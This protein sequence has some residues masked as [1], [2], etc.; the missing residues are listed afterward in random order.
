MFGG[1]NTFGSSDSISKVIKFNDKDLFSFFKSANS[2]FQYVSI[3]NYKIDVTVAFID[4]NTGA[5]LQLQILSTSTSDPVTMFLTNRT[6]VNC[7]NSTVL[8]QQSYR[9]TEKFDNAKYAKITLLMPATPSRKR[10]N[11][12]LFDFAISVFVC[13]KS[14]KTCSNPSYNGCVTCS[15]PNSFISNEMCVCIPGYSKDLFDPE[16]RCVKNTV[17]NIISN[18]AVSMGDLG[19]GSVLMN[20]ISMNSIYCGGNRTILGGY[21]NKNA[22]GHYIDIITSDIGLSFYMKHISLELVTEDDNSLIYPFNILHNRN[23]VPI[24]TFTTNK[25]KYLKFTDA[26]GLIGNTCYGTNNYKSYLITFY[27]FDNTPITD[28]S[29]INEIN[30]FW[31][32]LK[33]TVDYFNCHSNCNSCL[34]YGIDQCTSCPTGTV[35]NMAN[36]NSINKTSSCLC[37]SAQGYLQISSNY[38]PLTCIHNSYYN[39][40]YYNFMEL[41]E[42]QFSPESWSSNN[43]QLSSSDVKICDNTK[44]LGIYNS[45]NQ[46]YLEKLLNITQNISDLKYSVLNFDFQVYFFNTLSNWVI[47]VFLDDQYVYGKSMIL[48]GIFSYSPSDETIYCDQNNTIFYRREITFSY[49]PSDYFNGIISPNPKIRIEVYP[50]TECLYD[51]ACGWGINNF[52]ISVNKM[53]P[54][55]GLLCQFRPFSTNPCLNTTKS[56]YCFPGYVENKMS[57]GEY[58]C[59]GK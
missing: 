40:T 53:I 47:K 6:T 50:D 44:I 32:I 20:H 15:D 10:F 13:H 46:K 38:D 11:F 17:K 24:N 25:L 36:Y 56:R 33:L 14:C 41:N 57:N 16:Y 12:G 4:W 45:K 52:T 27:I 51:T 43:G 23:P 39:Y 26:L 54:D 48:G 22:T 58:V 8:T 9:Y 1:Y 18:G 34:G 7:D 21:I 37:D 42:I 2:P 49:Y 55:Q 35:M 28:I 5:N 19:Y 3:V 29:I 31:G 59:I 30:S